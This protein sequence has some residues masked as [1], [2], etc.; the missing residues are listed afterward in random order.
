[1]K[2]T[3][4]KTDVIVEGKKDTETKI[5]NISGIDSTAENFEAYVEAISFIKDQNPALYDKIMNWD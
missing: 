4:V 2:L 1:M 5:D 3:D